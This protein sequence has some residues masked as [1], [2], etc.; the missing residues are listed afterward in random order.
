MKM[1]YNFNGLVDSNVEQKYQNAEDSLEQINT[2]EKIKEGDDQEALSK[3]NELIE[4]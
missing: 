1:S 4:L 3:T 2:I